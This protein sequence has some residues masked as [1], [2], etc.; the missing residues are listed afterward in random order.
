MKRSVLKHLLSAAV[1]VTPA[2]PAE[3]LRALSAPGLFKFVGASFAEAGPICVPVGGDAGLWSCAQNC[4][5][6]QGT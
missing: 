1:H 6:Q 2:E 4:Q 3:K 5:T